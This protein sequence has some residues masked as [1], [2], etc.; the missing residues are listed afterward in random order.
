[1]VTR[2]MA[3]T[4]SSHVRPIKSIEVNGNFGYGMESEN[5]YPAILIW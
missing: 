5:G 3:T 2:V 4:L 1:M